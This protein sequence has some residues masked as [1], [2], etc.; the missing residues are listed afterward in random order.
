MGVRGAFLEVS[1]R[2]TPKADTSALVGEGSDTHMLIEFFALASASGLN[3][4]Q[5]CSRMMRSA[6]FSF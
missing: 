6:D 1:R 4:G 3:G 5:F 2:V